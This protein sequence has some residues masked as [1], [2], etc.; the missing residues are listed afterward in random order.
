MPTE[1]MEGSDDEKVGHGA[2]SA[3]DSVTRNRFAGAGR[4][5]QGVG[6]QVA[7]A[8][9]IHG[10]ASQTGQPRMRDSHGAALDL[11]QGG[12]LNLLKNSVWRQTGGA[13]DRRVE[14][15]LSQ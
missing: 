10:T 7:D 8:G 5:G 3:R 14:T 1:Q 9:P 4:G 6:H 13:E 11:N 2:K 12:R 15:K